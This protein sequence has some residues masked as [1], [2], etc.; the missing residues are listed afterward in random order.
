MILRIPFRLHSIGRYGVVAIITA[1]ALLLL[2][3][4]STA[5]RLNSFGQ[6]WYTIE[7]DHFRIHYQQGLLGVAK[8]TGDILERLYSIYTEEY[9]IRLPSKTDALVSNSDMS[10]GWALAHSNMIHIWSN[11]FDWNMRGTHDWLED[12]VAH[13]FAHVVSIWTANKLPRWMPYLQAGY[14]SHPNDTSTIRTGRVE[15]TP[16]GTRTE[17]HRF[18]PNEILPPW[19]YEGIAQF[20]SARNEGD[21][22]D[23][24]RDMI[25]R[26]VVMSKTMLSW[27]HMFVFI[28]QGDDYEKVYNHGFS[29]IRYI[30]E[31]YG[32]EKVVLFLRECGKVSV[33]S[34]DQA[35]REVLGISGRELYRDWKNYLEKEYSSQI[36]A[37]GKQVYGRKI[38]KKGFNNFFPRFS[39]DGEHVFFLSNGES[40]SF[41][42][43]LHS[44][45]MSDTVEDDK[46]I[47]VRM[48]QVGNAYDIHDSLNTILFS[49]MHSKKSLLPADEGGIR[50][51]DLFIDTI[52][53]EKKPLFDF[54]KT[55]R[56]VTEQ[57]SVFSGSFSPTGDRIACARRDVDRFYLCLTDTS[58]KKLRHLYPAE[59]DPNTIIRA[60][61]SVDWSPDGR[62]IAVSFIDK[63]NRKIGIYDTTSSEFVLL[64]DTEHDERDPRFGPDGKTVY[65]SSDRTGIFNIYRYDLEQG[66][67]Q[68]VT[69]VSGG[70]FTPDVSPD[71][72]RLVFANYDPDGYGIYLLDSITVLEDTLSGGITPYQPVARD[73]IKTVFTAPVPYSRL[74]RKPMIIPSVFGEELVTRE[75]DPFSGQPS[76]K[77]GAILGLFDPLALDGP[78]S[79]VGAYLLFDP[80]DIDNLFG[81]SYMDFD[82]GMYGSTRMFPLDVSLTAEVRSITGRDEFKYYGYGGDTAT[83]LILDYS[84]VPRA[85]DLTISH[86]IGGGDP[87][88][89]YMGLRL[90]GSAGYSVYDQRFSIQDYPF[91]GNQHD[92]EQK[93]EFARGYRFSLWSTFLSMKSSTKTKMM[94]S[95]RGAYAKLVYDI[96]GQDLYNHDRAVLLNQD[97][98]DFYQ[99]HQV[100]GSAKLGTPTPWNKGLDLYLEAS[101][102]TVALTEANKE[103]LR[104]KGMEDELPSFHEPI[105]WIPGYTYYFKDTARDALG[106]DT[107]VY[108]TVLVSGNFVAQGLFSYRFPLW[109]EM[110]KK[111]GW[112]Y[113]N[114]LYAALNVSGGAAWERPT[115]LLDFD[116]E[117]WLLA[118]GAE[119]RLAGLSFSNFPLYA[120]LK[121]DWGFDK[122]APIGGHRF[123]FSV[124]YSFDF[125][126][127]IDIRDWSSPL[128]RLRASNRSVGLSRRSGMDM[129]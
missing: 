83:T 90:Y 16:I 96:Y 108:D 37:I 56:Q 59:G 4:S 87:M 100:S 42:Q 121:W 98:Y 19:F 129:R 26:T 40:V 55:E 36:E 109:M 104:G 24:H 51:R 67:L 28:G 72:T 46:R 65:F 11:G 9:D 97:T 106:N 119:I 113:F 128:E 60:I 58:G 126:E 117:D 29:L 61:Y 101:G 107:L 5:Q 123:L 102:T 27:D 54:S 2:S 31:T 89:P 17:I 73:E 69:N 15:K 63:K 44:Y 1:A 10:G 62:R 68:R 76:L 82:M 86:A 33:L 8:E 88:A 39:P 41:R 50:T 6:K 43:V 22:W 111:L 80:T 116:R 7:S 94:G 21:A 3:G 14:F 92:I 114:D 20:E 112:M 18:F 75:E 118:F 47:T 78:G 12:V 79:E 125:W 35:I 115:D 122:P 105:A 127:Y 13:E 57:K 49:S 32:Y 85:A 48:P 23:S 84:L 93:V 38:N 45:A 71:G 110:D 91:G 81:K 30:H 95:P 77:I 53:Y 124:G 34:I 74:P 120:K 66:T 99:F 70:A 25:M 64:C 52:R 103:Y